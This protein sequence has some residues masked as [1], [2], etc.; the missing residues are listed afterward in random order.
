MERLTVYLA[1]GMEAAN[2]LGEYWR[3]SITPFLKSLNFKV[4][5]PCEFEPEQ[6]KGMHL[7][8]LPDYY[9]DLYGN[10]IKPTH[11]HQLKNATERVYYNRFLKYMRLIIKYDVNVVRNRTNIVVVL[12]DEAASK[13]AGTHAELTEAFLCNIPVYCVAKTDV[14]AWAKACCTEI[15]LNFDALKEFLLLEFMEVA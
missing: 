6:L 8:R 2:S 15:F 7:N 3:Q 12:W 14:P 5:N 1:G 10:Q 13:G 9:T 4:L 11:W